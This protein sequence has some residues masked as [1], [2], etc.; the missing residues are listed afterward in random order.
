MSHHK[1]L[2]LVHAV[3]GYKKLDGFK[4]K[5]LARKLRISKQL[6]SQYL[7]G[8]IVMPAGIRKKITEILNFEQVV[9]QMKLDDNEV[10]D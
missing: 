4:Y 8:D 5:A 3:V 6:L 9:H 7:Q 1:F 2:K 10:N